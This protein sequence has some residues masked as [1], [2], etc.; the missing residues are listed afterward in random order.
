MAD[1][2]DLTPEAQLAVRKYVSNYLIGIATLIGIANVV[3]IFG[4]LY[5]LVGEAARHPH[6]QE[7]RGRESS[8]A[9]MT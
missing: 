1:D 8:E 3:A 5:F 7:Q 4:A 6:A 2:I 9:T